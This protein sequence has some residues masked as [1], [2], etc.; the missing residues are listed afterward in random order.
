MGLLV[1]Y[2]GLFTFIFLI[3]LILADKLVSFLILFLSAI[4]FYQAY[5]R[6]YMCYNY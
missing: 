2:L 5:Q 6:E 1:F 3:T 4:A